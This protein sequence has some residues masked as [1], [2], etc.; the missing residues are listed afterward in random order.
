V[1]ACT[2]YNYLSIRDLQTIYAITK[3]TDIDFEGRCHQVR[4][5]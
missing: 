2:Q 4:C 5:C 3:P 1:H